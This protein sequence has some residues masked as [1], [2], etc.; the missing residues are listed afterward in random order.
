MALMMMTGLINFRI[1]TGR[2]AWEVKG[3][4]V[5][6]IG[7]LQYSDVGIGT[8][9]SVSFK[10]GAGIMVVFQFVVGYVFE[11]GVD[12]LAKFFLLLHICVSTAP[13]PFT[14]C[15]GFHLFRL[16]LRWVLLFLFLFR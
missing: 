1:E 10:V 4:A 16:L 6:G 8:V 13:P 9:L 3:R 7:E 14:A 15:G 12:F 5:L 11:I 2:T